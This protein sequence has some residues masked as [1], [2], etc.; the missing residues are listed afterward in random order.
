VHQPVATVRG[1]VQVDYHL[2][3]L[4][5][6]PTE[7][8]QPLAPRN[9]LVSVDP[10]IA[11]IFTGISSGPVTVQV[12]TRRDPPPPPDPVGWDEI[13]DISLRAP[14]GQLVVQGPMS[15]PP[16]HF[17]NLAVTGPDA[18]RIRIHARGRDSAVDL[19]VFEPVEDYLII[20]WPAPTA[21]EIVHKH[22]D[23]YGSELRRTLA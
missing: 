21:T 13:I 23:R 16:Q 12:Q 4:R 2:L 18:Y 1:T 3:Y 17:P 6:G 22:T 10:G 5:D 19:A 14:T 20:T 7:P 9:G 15:D 11:V 8:R